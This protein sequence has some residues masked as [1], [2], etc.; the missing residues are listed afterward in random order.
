MG[1]NRRLTTALFALAFTGSALWGTGCSKEKE[2]TR[3]SESP[4][5]AAAEPASA[6]TEAPTASAEVDEANRAERA[7]RA[8]ARRAAREARGGANQVEERLPPVLTVEDHARRAERE[9][10]DKNYGAFLDEL[11][12]DIETMERASAPTR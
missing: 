6:A 9:I 10:D 11:E 5:A 4:P 7:E 1:L 8:A 2:R 3:P 12:K